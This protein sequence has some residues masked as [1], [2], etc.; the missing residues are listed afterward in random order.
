MVF[1]NK[2]IPA[3]ILFCFLLLFGTNCGAA[4]F[5]CEGD[6]GKITYR[7]SPCPGG[8]NES[9]HLLNDGKS[10]KNEHELNSSRNFEFV[11]AIQ[12]RD[13]NSVKRLLVADPAFINDALPIHN[14]FQVNALH[15][16][17]GVTDQKI[18]AL[19][20]DLGA[21]VN[22][23]DES[24]RTPMFYAIGGLKPGLFESRDQ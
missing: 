1:P 8:N 14:L 18:A 12:A 16:A 4:A 17:A 19:L 22:A 13:Y 5:K 23:R 11:R 2:S 24:G 6:D 9:I 15:I 3:S 21:D 20:L 7:D 10:K